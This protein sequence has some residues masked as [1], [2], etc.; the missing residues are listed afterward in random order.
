MGTDKVAFVV[1]LPEVTGPAG[2]DRALTGSNVTGS[3]ALFSR[4]FSCDVIFPTVCTIVVVQNV[5]LRMTDS[6]TGSD[7]GGVNARIRNRVSRLFS[8]T[9]FSNFLP[10]LFFRFPGLFSYYNSSTVVQVPWLPEETE[11][12]VTPKVT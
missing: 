3:D 11:G 7:P 8:R 9:P 6:A 2:S 12:H 10:I 1:V 4:F 5:S